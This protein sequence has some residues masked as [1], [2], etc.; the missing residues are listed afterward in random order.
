MRSNRRRSDNE[1]HVVAGHRDVVLAPARPHDPL[2]E[3]AEPDPVTL[4]DVAARTEAG[5]LEEVFDEAAQA[6]D[7]GD[8]EVHGALA[9]LRQL[10]AVE[11]QQ[12]GGADRGRDGRAQLVRDICAGFAAP[13]HR[14]DPPGEV[15]QLERLRDVVVRTTVQS[16]ARRLAC[17]RAR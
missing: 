16:P 12:T 13:H 8:H 3:R 6:A 2:D 11:L 1:L 9:F 17:R 14:A 5:D 4:H 10:V 7:V 15:S